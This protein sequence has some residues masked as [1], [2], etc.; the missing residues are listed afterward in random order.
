MFLCKNEPVGSH[1]IRLS[2][3][4]YGRNPFNPLHSAPVGF[5]YLV[6]STVNYHCFQDDTVRFA[7]HSQNANAGS[8]CKYRSQ[9][10]STWTSPKLSKKSIDDQLLDTT[11]HISIRRMNFSGVTNFKMEVH[12]SNGPQ[13]QTHMQVQICVQEGTR[14]RSTVV[15]CSR[16]SIQ[17][18]KSTRASSS[19]ALANGTAQPLHG[20]RWHVT[21]KV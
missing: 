13:E 20:T 12:A 21:T 16:A 15:R 7:L 18:P 10:L 11:H 5:G 1:G 6:S 3:A 9:K 17:F 19:Y 14:Q 4:R 8:C 2:L